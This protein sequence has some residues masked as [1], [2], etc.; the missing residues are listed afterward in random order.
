MYRGNSSAT[1]EISY[2]FTPNGRKLRS[3]SI[4][5]SVVLHCVAQ[6]L[7]SALRLRIYCAGSGHISAGSTSHGNFSLIKFCSSILPYLQL[8]QTV[9]W[10][11]A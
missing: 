10:A 1:E 3:R 7:L 2:L 11:L 8:H 4:K 9:L 6:P 5:R